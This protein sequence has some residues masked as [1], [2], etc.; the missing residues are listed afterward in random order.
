MDRL[1][2]SFQTKEEAGQLANMAELVA[3]NLLS[4]EKTK[5]N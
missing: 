1:A 4:Q 3:V 2:Q 5:M